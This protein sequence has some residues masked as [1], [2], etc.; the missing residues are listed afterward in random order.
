MVLVSLFFTSIYLSFCC[1]T[2][3]QWILGLAVLILQIMVVEVVIVILHV[4]HQTTLTL[5]V[6]GQC[7]LR[8]N[9]L[10]REFE[11][12]MWSLDKLSLN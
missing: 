4:G 1:R 11:K 10:F 7:N 8:D 5:M 3:N 9:Y 12:L 6:C 2:R